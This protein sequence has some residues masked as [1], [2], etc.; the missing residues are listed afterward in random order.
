MLTTIPQ[1]DIQRSGVGTVSIGQVGIG[2]IKIGQLV[3][4]DFALNTAGD[5]AFLRNFVVT[6]TYTMSLDWHLH[7]D[8][9]GHPIDE[10]GTEDLD[11][12]SFTVGFGDIRVPGI[13]NLKIDIAS[14]SVDNIAATANPVVNLQLGAAVA[15]QIQARN[16]KLPTQ[17]F[18]IAGQGI[19]ALN[20]GGFGAPAATLDSVTIGRVHG[21]AFPLGQMALS[22]LALPS[23]SIAD[24]VSQ[25]VDVTATPKPKAFH[26]DL[27]CLDLTLKVNPVAEAKIDQLVIRNV[28]ASTSIG[29]IELHNVV[30][31]Y[32]LLNLTLGQI[33]IDTIS[34]PTVAIA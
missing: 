3:L 33:G 28:T 19:G 27:G 26:L 10:T 18:S 11:S 13:E 31:P 24:I 5:G 25:G 8:F 1:A 30:A 29:K 6:V 2:P 32:E 23:A 15:E 4:T 20:V 34:V 16:L 17:G 12:P 14:L 7:I 9:P 21:D 22:N